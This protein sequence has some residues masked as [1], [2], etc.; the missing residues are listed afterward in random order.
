M[1]TTGQVIDGLLQG[2]Y[3]EAYTKYDSREIGLRMVEGELKVFDRYQG[4][5]KIHALKI[6][7][8]DFGL[9]WKVE[10]SFEHRPYELIVARCERIEPHEDPRIEARVVIQHYYNGSLHDF[11][12]SLHS[13]L[14]I[15]SAAAHE[16]ERVVILMEGRR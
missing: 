13:D 14:R 4:E 1:L 5:E 11:K 2:E 16:S 9:I 7:E 6:N 3:E 12:R 8:S 10:Y 15:V